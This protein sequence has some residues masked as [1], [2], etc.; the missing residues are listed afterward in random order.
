MARFEQRFAIKWL[1]G[2]GFDG[3][4]VRQGQTHALVLEYDYPDRAS[5]NVLRLTKHS[6]PSLPLIML[7]EQH[8]EELAVWAFHARVWDY[9]VKP[10]QSS[11]IASLHTELSQ[12]QQM[13]RRDRG[14]SSVVQRDD[15]LPVEV[16]VGALVD[17]ARLL[18]RV[19]AHISDHLADRISLEEMAGLC[20]M[21]P[22]RF[23]RFFKKS[24]GQTFQEYLLCQRVEKAAQLLHNRSALVVDVAY[25][26]GFRDPS[27]FARIFKRYKGVCP[28]DFR[29]QLG[30]SDL[31]VPSGSP[32]FLEP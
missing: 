23:S 1:S 7:T 21:T 19:E 5:L 28:V 13:Q 4:S 30:Q 22:Y 29:Q 2:D 18:Q 3:N 8:S 31:S 27:Y 11:Q 16:R 9:M 26:T 20:G 6:F 15:R 14:R 10:V 32:L 25:M 17:D 12:L 24:Y